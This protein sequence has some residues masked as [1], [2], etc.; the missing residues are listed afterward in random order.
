[1][2]GVFGTYVLPPG[3]EKAG[4]MIDLFESTMYEM[5]ASKSKL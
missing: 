2:C 4:K 1:M 3:D 5:N